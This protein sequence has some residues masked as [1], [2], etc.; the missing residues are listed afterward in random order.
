[1]YVFISSLGLMLFYIF[2]ISTNNS[3]YISWVLLLLILLLYSTY[4]AINGLRCN[5]FLPRASVFS[6]HQEMPQYFWY[7][8]TPFLFSD[9]SHLV[10]QYVIYFCLF[11]F[12][13]WPWILD[14]Q[15]ALMLPFYSNLSFG[16]LQRT[17]SFKY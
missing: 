17:C 13:G 15:I 9:P 3:V 11:V 16:P 2:I 6:F 4:S 12:L 7:I 1:M 10:P 14:R 5:F 8:R